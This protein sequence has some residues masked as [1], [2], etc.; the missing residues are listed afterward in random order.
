MDAIIPVKIESP[1]YRVDKDLN[2]TE[3]ANNCRISLDILEE[4]K[5][6]AAA[7]TEAR[8]QQVAHYFNKRVRSRTFNVGDLVLRKAEIGKGNAGIGKLDPNWERPYRVVEATEKG[9][10]RLEDSKGNTIPRY[11]NIESLRKY[12]Q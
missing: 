1:S 5:E 2:K 11:W 4:R 8:R 12:Y 3:N 10:Y 7:I 9:A 6:Q